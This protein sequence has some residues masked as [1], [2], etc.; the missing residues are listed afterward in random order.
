MIGLWYREHGYQFLAFTDHNVLASTE[1]WADI[2]KTKGGRPAFEKLR[3]RWP[4]QVETRTH[5]G[6]EQVRL[7]RFD[8]AAKLLNDPDKYLLIQGEEISDSFDKLPIHV[9]ANHVHELIPPRHGQSVYEVI[10]NNV[11]AVLAQRKL[12]GQPMLVHLNHPNFHYVVTAEDMMRVD[13]EQFFEVYNGH[14][15]TFNNGDALHASTERI[16]DIVLAHRLTD[17]QLPI[18]Y[19]LATDDGHSYHHIPSRKSEPGRG[20][21]MVLA[22]ELTPAALIEALEAG[23]FYASSGV[24]L[25]RIESSPEGLDVVVA[26]E[27]G[28]TYAIEFF[29]TRRSA[30]LHGEPVLDQKGLPVRTTLRYSQD[31]GAV[32]KSVSGGRARYQFGGDELYV[33]ARVT[34][35]ARHPNPSEIGDLKRAWTQPVPGPG[36]K[37]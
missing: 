21:V 36:I 23:R 6:Q 15:E 4:D 27:P 13:G 17:L 10:Q 20:W 24:S 8:E 33:R 31:V 12:T 22:A 34:S 32:L 35:S 9:N 25:A 16:W 30:D 19:G 14:P 28:E 26:E 37:R 2:D 29:G 7:L 18:L 3:A 1:R 5:E 11:D